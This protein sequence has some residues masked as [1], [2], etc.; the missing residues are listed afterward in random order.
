MH[1]IGVKYV[2]TDLGVLGHARVL[3]DLGVSAL[4][5]QYLSEMGIH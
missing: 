1:S 2:F 3:A 5:A 4:V